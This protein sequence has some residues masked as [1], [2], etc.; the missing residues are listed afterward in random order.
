MNTNS[1]KGSSGSLIALII[2]LVVIILGGWHFWQERAA[3][4]AANEIATSTP[5][6]ESIN[7]QSSSD[8]TGSILNDLE[9]TDTTHVDAG[10][11]AQ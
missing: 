2:I 3:T 6:I 1:S 11:D 7:T 4:R 10:L 5:S 9:S 8:D